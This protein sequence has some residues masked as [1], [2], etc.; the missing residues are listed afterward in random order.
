MMSAVDLPFLNADCVGPIN[1]CTASFILSRVMRNKLFF[2]TGTMQ[3]DV[4]FSGFGVLRGLGMGIRMS[5]LIPMS[6]P[7]EMA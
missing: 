4:R 5:E 1:S 2:N 6:F 7:N 3:L